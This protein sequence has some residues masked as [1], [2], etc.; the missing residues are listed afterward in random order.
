MDKKPKEIEIKNSTF[1]NFIITNKK[2]EIAS[3]IDKMNKT[4]N[5]DIKIFTTSFLPTYINNNDILMKDEYERFCLNKY[6]IHFPLKKMSGK[7]L[8]KT[9]IDLIPSPYKKINKDLI[10]LNKKNIMKKVHIS[11]NKNVV[12]SNYRPYKLISKNINDNLTQETF[13]NNNIQIDNS[14]TKDFKSFINLNENNNITNNKLSHKN[15]QIKSIKKLNKNNTPYNRYYITASNFTPNIESKKFQDL[16][17]NNK[18]NIFRKQL[19]N[20]LKIYDANQSFD[21]HKNDSKLKK[22]N[23]N[24]LKTENNSFEEIK[25]LKK[26]PR[27]NLNYWKL[28]EIENKFNE[29]YKEN[30]TD[31][32]E[33]NRII[34]RIKEKCKILLEEIDKRNNYEIQ[35]IKNEIKTKLLGLGFNE[36]F[37]YLLAI[38]QNYDKKI[39]NWSYEIKEEKKECP[40]ELKYR[41][42][43]YKHKKFMGLL[44]RQYV[45]GVNANNRMDFL[46][47]NGKKK[48]G[49]DNKNDYDNIYFNNI[50]CNSPD[51][52]IDNIF[53]KRNYKSKY[54]EIFYRNK[55]K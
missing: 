1:K 37:R 8:N 25:P 10:S 3:K 14:L 48:L 24:Y 6:N 17:L 11:L 47:K 55:N 32:N 4:E 31:V 39:V 22:R 12:K 49:F 21:L 15:K 30:F 40:E 18:I 23:Y 42:I 7:K 45:C 36:F 51:K 13:D 16:Y 19:N 27:I 26:I 38:L 35:R 33:K 50:T 53:N 41:N 44:N 2:S 52:L 9:K 20:N 43:R 46:I 5:N 54:F 34:Q 29:M 28:I